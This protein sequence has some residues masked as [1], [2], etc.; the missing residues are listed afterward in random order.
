MWPLASH[1][2]QPDRTRL[3]GVL[4]GLAGLVLINVNRQYLVGMPLSAE[5]RAVA[6]SLL[7]AIP[8]IR[9]VTFFCDAIR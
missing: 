1:A 3:I 2:Q 6:L 5:R 8:E 4:M 9:R 7:R